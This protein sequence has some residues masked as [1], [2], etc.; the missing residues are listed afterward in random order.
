MEIPIEPYIP[1]LAEIDR[2]PVTRL[3]D[4]AQDILS[5]LQRHDGNIN[6]MVNSLRQ[7][8]MITSSQ[9]LTAIYLTLNKPINAEIKREFE[10]LREAYNQA[11][12]VQAQS[13]GL[14]YISH[15]QPP[16]MNQIKMNDFVSYAKLWLSGPI[17]SETIKGRKQGAQEPLQPTD[18]D[19]IEA[20][21]T[22]E[23][24]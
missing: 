6:A 23:K 15:F 19:N 13:K 17:A 3:K 5:Y 8:S 20:E 21:L 18:L 1:K 10:E 12:Y 4:N 22:S 24:S 16:D 2:Y 7:G 11:A 14:E 9:V